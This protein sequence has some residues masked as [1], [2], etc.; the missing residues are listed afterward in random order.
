MLFQGF[1]FTGVDAIE[2]FSYWAH[3]FCQGRALE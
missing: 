2:S 3:F 1:I